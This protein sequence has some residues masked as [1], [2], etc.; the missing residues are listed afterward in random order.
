MMTFLLLLGGFWL[1]VISIAIL[2]FAAAAH[3][4]QPTPELDITT[5]HR[6]RLASS[7]CTSPIRHRHTAACTH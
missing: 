7:P 4:H 2:A 5:P 6:R 3:R 1:G